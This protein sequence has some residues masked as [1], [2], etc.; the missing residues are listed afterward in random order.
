MTKVKETVVGE[1]DAETTVL[2]ALAGGHPYV[3]V[4]TEI[5]GDGCLDLKLS[6]GGG[7]RE[8]STIRTILEKVLEALP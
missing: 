1:E 8:S 5:L 3:F 7:V 2:N 6:V 4:V